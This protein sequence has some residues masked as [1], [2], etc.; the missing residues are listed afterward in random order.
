MQPGAHPGRQVPGVQE[1]I[2]LCLDSALRHIVE[3]ILP[4][5]RAHSPQRRTSLIDAGTGDQVSSFRHRVH[6]AFIQNGGHFGPE[7]RRMPQQRPC[8]DSG[9][10]REESQRGA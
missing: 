3:Q 6:A 2:Q 9:G 4:I 8:R 5:G 7:G 1:R 10:R